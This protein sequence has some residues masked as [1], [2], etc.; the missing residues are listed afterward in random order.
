[1]ASF[2]ESVALGDCEVVLSAPA[3]GAAAAPLARARCLLRVG[4]PAEV[5][6]AVADVPASLRGY[7][8]L[9]TARA[10]LAQGDREGAAAALVGVKLPGEAGADAREL[11][12]TLAGDV[13]ALLAFGAKRPSALLAAAEVLRAQGDAAAAA[14]VW[15]G[16][17]TAAEP[18]GAD[19]AA[20]EA[21]Q[22]AGIDPLA[23]PATRARRLAA[24]QREHRA[25]EALEL[26]A[27]QPAPTT[28]DG[29]IQL[30]EVRS[31]AR[32]HAGALEAWAHAY[33]PPAKATGS[34]EGLFAYALAHARTG[35][36]DTAGVVYRRIPVVAPK[37]GEADHAAFKLGYM[38]VDRGRCAE[39]APLLEA[40][41]AAY[42]ASKRLDETLWWLA[43]CADQAGDAA[44]ADRWYA[45][46][47]KARPK[48]SLVAGAAYWTARHRPEAEQAAALLSVARRFP[49]SAYA[50]LVHERAGT[51]FPA[52]PP[53]PAPALPAAVTGRPEWSR[54][55]AL[56][57]VGLRDW[58]AGELAVVAPG[59]GAAHPLAIADA[60]LAVGR[61]DLARKLACPLAGAPGGD[62][63]AAD[64]R[65]W[66]QV[67]AASLAAAGGPVAPSVVWGVMTAESA[68]DPTVSSAVGARGLMQLMPTLG[69]ELH[70]RWF[71]ATPYDPDALYSA[72]YNALL[73]ATELADRARTLDGVL[74]DT[75]VPAVVASYNAGEEPVRR[76]AVDRPAADVFVESVG[77]V[78]TRGYVKRVLGA[79]MAWRAVW[80]DSRSSSD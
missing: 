38:E 21:L 8:A 28:A 14:D 30:G 68:L 18:G 1:M 27:S 32:D 59:L 10:A 74:A 53:L 24:L 73:G 26:A 7:G 13:D 29:W 67:E 15:R 16:V 49:D 62:A 4:R 31:A 42:P 79:A 41:R 44:G 75:D 47:A 56:A 61:V 78:E 69:A 65:C 20:F 36:Y 11:A 50:W 34:A 80:G 33:G 48:S 66:P 46:L 58:A 52:K 2:A 9:L 51:V 37:S 54:Y 17:W 5:A 71:P 19:R 39:A 43:R 76:W 6:G 23:E 63:P 60:W 70:P 77:Y 35:D 12:A 72:P 57:E 25:A 45:E 64:Q 22:A 40:H 3:P 55:A